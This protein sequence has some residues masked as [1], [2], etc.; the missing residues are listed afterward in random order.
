[1][2]SC[3]SIIRKKE[4]QRKKSIPLNTKNYIYATDYQNYNSK[5]NKSMNKY[6]ISN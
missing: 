2:G 4:E 5:N 3:A 6:H 1:M